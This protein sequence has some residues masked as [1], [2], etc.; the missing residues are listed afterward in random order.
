MNPPL[1]A[2]SELT[3]KHG[4]YT[5]SC[6]RCRDEAH[7]L[8]DGRRLPIPTRPLLTPET[9]QPTVLLSGSSRASPGGNHEISRS[10]SRSKLPA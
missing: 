3:C 8:T 10:F 5:R 9:V 2:G 6:Q 1:K 7:E 4:R